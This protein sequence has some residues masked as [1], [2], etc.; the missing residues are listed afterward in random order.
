MPYWN[1]PGAKFAHFVGDVEATCQ[2][3]FGHVVGFVSQSGLDQKHQDFKW[4]LASY[5][6]PICGS[7]VRIEEATCWASLAILGPVKV[8]GSYSSAS[9]GKLG[10]L[11]DKLGY[12]EVMLKLR[13][14]MLCHVEAIC[15]I[16]FGH[17]GMLVVLHPEMPSP[18]QDQDFKW[19]SASYVGSIGGPSTAILWLSWHCCHHLGINFGHLGAH[20]DAMWAQFGDTTPASPKP[21]LQNALPPWPSRRNRMNSKNQPKNKISPKTLTPMVGKPNASKKHPKI[22][23]KK[24][25]PHGS[26][27]RL[28]RKGPLAELYEYDVFAEMQSLKP[29]A[30]IARRFSR[31]VQQALWPF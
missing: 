16:L 30:P 29:R 13:W 9:C 21:T 22:R 6:G 17:V 24:A 5:L 25:N 31:F 26:R 3:L 11:E 23:L 12:R 27:A 4:V 20:D 7:N 18:Q 10:D 2:M 14:A 15:Q 8:S 1:H 19:V 28:K